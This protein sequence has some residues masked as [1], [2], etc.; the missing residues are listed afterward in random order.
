[1]SASISA[2]D[3]TAQR[4]AA[5]QALAKVADDFREACTTQEPEKAP[6]T[7]TDCVHY[8]RDFAAFQRD[9]DAACEREEHGQQ[10]VPYM[11]KNATG[12]LGDR[13][14]GVEIEFDISPGVDPQVAIAK[15][16]RDLKAAGLSR[17]AQIYQYHTQKKEGYTRAPNEWRLETDGTLTRGA[18]LVSPIL[19][20]D[21]QSWRSLA[22][23]C[24]I[25]LE[26]GG[27]ASRQTGGHV[28]VGMPDYG[29]DVAKFSC[30]LR[31]F[32]AH[33]DVLYRLAQNPA[34]ADQKHRGAFWCQ[35]NNVPSENYRAISQ[36]EIYHDDAINLASAF[37]G[38]QGA[39]GE[40]RWWDGSLNPSVIQTQVKLSLALTAAAAR[41]D[42]TIV[43]NTVI[44]VGTHAKKYPLRVE[45]RQQEWGD[46]WKAET[47]IFRRMID[48]LFKRSAD[49]EQATALFQQTRWQPDSILE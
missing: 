41:G 21:S 28:H 18:E 4:A 3:V 2:A 27:Q 24:R 23:A 6:E 1:M 5:L 49:K 48:D 25:I 31:M 40:F 34:A 20:D 37:G 7:E 15:I 9:Y 32:N 8:T 13:G 38:G 36:I 42:D 14:F 44:P 17:S 11:T 47:E 19:G 16:G 46:D 39:H 10:P 29:L 43:P 30:L 26:N 12:G 35:V 22:T 33:Q 45:Q